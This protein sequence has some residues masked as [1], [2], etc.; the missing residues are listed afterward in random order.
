M[1]VTGRLGAQLLAALEAA[2]FHN[3]PTG[4]SGHTGTKTVRAGTLT[5]VGLMCS[6]WHAF[7]YPSVVARHILPKFSTICKRFSTVLQRYPKIVHKST[8]N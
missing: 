6:F 2:S 4:L 1:N 7:T 5:G 3:E 8:L